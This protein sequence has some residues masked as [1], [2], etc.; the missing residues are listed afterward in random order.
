MSPLPLPPSL[1]Q[2]RRASADLVAT[3]PP[4]P[5]PHTAKA[6]DEKQTEINWEVALNVCDKVNDDGETGCVHRLLPSP[7][8]F[9]AWLRSESGC[10]AKYK[11]LVVEHAR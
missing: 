5:L 9:S 7:P 2:R 11:L 4:A 3:L 10:C 8:L 6:T 1:G